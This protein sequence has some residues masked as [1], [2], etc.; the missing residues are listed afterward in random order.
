[1]AH[2]PDDFLFSQSSLQD[3]ADCPLRFYLRWI[4]G[5]RYPAPESEP[6]REYEART[7]MGES[8]HTLL[9]QHTIGIQEDVLRAALT[10]PDEAALTGWFDAALAFL[11][12]ADLPAARHAEIA[13]SIPLPAHGRRLIARYDLL[14]IDPGERAVIIDWKT[15][16]RRPTRAQLAARWQTRLYPFVL[17][18]AGAAL[19]G[20]PIPPERISM[21]YWFAA[22]P[23]EPEVFNWDA[24]SDARTAAMLDAI[25]GEIAARHDDEADFPLTTDE[26]HC[27]FC[28]YRSYTR[29]GE[30][31]IVSEQDDLTDPAPPPDLDQIDAIAF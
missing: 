16:P 3:Y 31:G 20:A 13:L 6:M 30:A 26:Q 21:I 10:D 5:L 2:L 17:A 4:K 8:L 29:R 18:R 23:D 25:T 14:A 7:L 1:M 9:H 22:Q 15:A 27:R 11:A 28:V 24:E 19:Y 12:H